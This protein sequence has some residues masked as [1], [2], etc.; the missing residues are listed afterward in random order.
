MSSK[1]N[2]VKI[3]KINTCSPYILACTSDA[4]TCIVL[5]AEKKQFPRKQFVSSSQ[6]LVGSRF[7]RLISNGF[8]TWSTLRL[9]CTTTPDSLSD[10]EGIPLSYPEGYQSAHVEL[11][12]LRRV[13]VY[14]DSPVNKQGELVLHSLGYSVASDLGFSYPQLW[15]A[16]PFQ[17]FTLTI[18]SS[19]LVDICFRC[20]HFIRDFKS[21]FL[22]SSTQGLKM[23]FFQ[24]S[25][26]TRRSFRTTNFGAER[27]T[28]MF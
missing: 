7:Y 22:V 13:F 17:L 8:Q 3:L 15:F 9:H 26:L 18:L 14:Y 5:Q 2:S 16:L 12:P 6:K 24:F 25:N 10:G 27:W 28:T 11:V 21:D 1:L 4:T 20:W 19:S 23:D